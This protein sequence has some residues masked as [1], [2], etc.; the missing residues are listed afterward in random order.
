MSLFRKLLIEQK[1]TSKYDEFLGILLKDK[2]VIPFSKIPA[3]GYLLEDVIGVTLNSKGKQFCIH[4]SAEK[5]CYFGGATMQKPENYSGVISGNINDVIND[6]D[7]ETNTSQII[8]TGQGDNSWACKYSRSVDFS[9]LE[10]YVMSMGEAQLI[11]PFLP[12][13]NYLLSKCGGLEIKKQ[14]YWTSSLNSVTEETNI[15]TWAWITNLRG[16]RDGSNVQALMF[17]RPI[18]KYN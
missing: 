12:Q 1:K 5:K 15:I 11:E 3:T 10:G 13:I 7:G 14:N 8:S 17:V 2:K 6:M 18:A 4:P 16:Y 9:G